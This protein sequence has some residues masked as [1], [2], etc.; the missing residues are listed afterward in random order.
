VDLAYAY[1]I[2][3]LEANV[4]S[5]RQ[6]WAI[7]AAAGGTDNLPPIQDIETA[8]AEFDAALVAPIVRDDP[9]DLALMRA[10]G[11]AA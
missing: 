11:V 3:Q 9:D 1:M 7:V 8:R 6:V 4:R 10:I 5:D 2:E